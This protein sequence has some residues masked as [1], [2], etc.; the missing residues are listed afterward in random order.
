MKTDDPD[1]DLSKLLNCWET[2]AMDLSNVEHNVR[3]QIALQRLKPTLRSRLIDLGQT[4]KQ[5]FSLRPM[6]GTAVTALA[7]L[8]GSVGGF[9]I[10]AP[11]ADRISD[12]A[13]VAYATEINPILQARN[14]R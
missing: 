12:R 9:A 14:P 7:I 2:P 11:T 3:R 13:V 5:A 4:W 6:L 1:R 10:G 8:L